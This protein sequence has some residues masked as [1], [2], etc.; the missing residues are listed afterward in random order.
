MRVLFA[1]ICV[2]LLFSACAP[3]TYSIRPADAPETMFQNIPAVNQ[4][5]LSPVSTQTPA[6]PTQSSQPTNQATVLTGTCTDTDSGKDPA[7]KGTVTFIVQDN[8]TTTTDTCLNKEILLERYCELGQVM[9]E[10]V[11]C[12]KN[13][14]ADA[15]A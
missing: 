2:L 4:P 14:L 12:N 6:Q 15:C 1:F 8:T 13:C 10:K 11:L 3:Q 7:K 5:T 9:T